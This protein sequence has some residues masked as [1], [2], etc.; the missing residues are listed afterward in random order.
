M[1]T[2]P[3][4]S[5]LNER[6]KRLASSEGVAPQRIRNRLGFQ[7]ILARLTQD[8]DWVLKGGFSL[9]IRLGL[10]ARATKDLDVLHLGDCLTD[11][12][13]L[14]DLIDEA[15]DRDLGDSFTFRARR[16]RQIR[17]EDGD[18]SSWRIGVDTFYFGS[19]FSSTTMDIVSSVAAKAEDTE[20]LAVTPVLIGEPFQ[21]MA[22]DLERHAAEKYHAYAR[23]YAHDRPSSRVKDLVDL[24]VLDET[25]ELDDAELGDAIRRVFDERDQAEPPDVLPEPPLDW[26]RT[27]PPMAEETGVSV[28]NVTDAWR[29][30]AAMYARA[31]RQKDEA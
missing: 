26:A 9:E 3:E 29:V 6:I 5:A 15:L 18:P 21:V 27:Y 11:A 22:L 1:A 7:R 28:T 4:A 20:P 13:L 8:P 17:I 24:V 30:A 25:G 23:I 2:S 14:Q 10:R 19:P 31:L 12:D 16:P